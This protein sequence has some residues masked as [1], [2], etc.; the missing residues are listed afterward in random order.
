LEIRC[1]ECNEPITIETEDPDIKI[2]H[3][4]CYTK[5]LLKYK[6]YG[7]RIGARIHKKK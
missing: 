6:E 3:P 7:I 5:F 4:G 2:F 1:R